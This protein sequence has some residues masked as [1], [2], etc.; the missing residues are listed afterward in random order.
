MNTLNTSLLGERYG[1]IVIIIIIEGGGT[2][3]VLGRSFF[4]PS[5][6]CNSAVCVCVRI[7]LPSPIYM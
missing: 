5:P 1:D 7:S 3:L 2:K 4:L 6:R